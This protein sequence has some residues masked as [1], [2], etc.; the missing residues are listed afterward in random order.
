V[1]GPW[2]DA[3]ADKS[4]KKTA[5]SRRSFKTSGFAYVLDL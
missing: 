1:A 3:A 2:A 5:L 4:K